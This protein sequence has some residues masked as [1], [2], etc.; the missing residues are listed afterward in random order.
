MSKMYQILKISEVEFEKSKQI[1]FLTPTFKNEFR[2]AILEAQYPEKPV[3]SK[4]RAL[5]MLIQYETIK[6]EQ[7]RHI[8]QKE[9]D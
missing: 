7:F 3:L 1:L 4:E 2:Q 8:N 9:L 5:G 6:R